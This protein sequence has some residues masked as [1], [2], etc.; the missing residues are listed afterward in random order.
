MTSKAF[1]RLHIPTTTIK[2]RGKSRLPAAKDRAPEPNTIRWKG[3][4]DLSVSWIDGPGRW[5]Y[6]P[7]DS[8]VGSSHI[9]RSCELDQGFNLD[10]N[11][12]MCYV[13]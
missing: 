3:V 8:A 2:S 13:S 7:L 5:T 1:R 9:L 10:L 11:C 12:V 4:R 6:M